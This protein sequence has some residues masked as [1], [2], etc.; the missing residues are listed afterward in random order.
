MKQDRRRELNH[1]WIIWL[2][3]TYHPQIVFAAEFCLAKSISMFASP[4]AG[5]VGLGDQLAVAAGSMV[6]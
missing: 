3:T 5:P 2:K 6:A 4:M 1:K